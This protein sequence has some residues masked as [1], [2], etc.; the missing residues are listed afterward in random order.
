MKLSTVDATSCSPS[1]R[2]S[3]ASPP[4][5]ARSRRSPASSSP[6][7]DGG[8]ELRATDMEVGLRVPLDAEV[9]REGAVVLPARLLLDV[10][11]SLP[12]RRA[13]TLELRPAEQDV[14]LVAGHATLPHPHAARRGLPAAPRAERR[15]AV[16]DVPGAGVRRDRRPGRPLG[17]ARRDAPDP[18]RHPRLGVRRSEL[19]MVATDS[20]RLSVKE[21]HARGAARAAASR[22]TCRRARCRSWRAIVAARRSR[23]DHRQRARRTRSSSR[24]AAWCCPRG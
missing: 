4:R 14:E 2:P 22:P 19:R 13:S 6:P 16:V 23:G 1:C 15:R 11:R 5:A 3:P 12:A 10:V 7:S 18:H 8:V 24:S 17:L 20:Y 21:T 9:E